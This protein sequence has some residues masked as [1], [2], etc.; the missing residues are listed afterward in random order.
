MFTL[1]KQTAKLTNV[2]PRSELHG[3]EKHLA[4]DLNFEIAVSNDVL[5]EFSPTLKSSLYRKLSNGEGDLLPEEPGTLS[6]LKYPELCPVKWNSQLN[7]YEMVIHYGVTKTQDIKLIDC[8]VDKF[9][10]D[11]QDGGTVIVQF[12]IVAHPEPTELGRLCEMIQQE[13][14]MTLIEPA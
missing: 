4:A 14:E 9:R 7:G 5:S 12:R 8:T 13:V 6:K 11:C 10:F 3:E 1:Q 2:N